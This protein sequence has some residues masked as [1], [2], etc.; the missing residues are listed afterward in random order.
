YYEREKG[1]ERETL[2]LAVE[3]ALM[4][5]SRKSLSADKEIRVEVDRDTLQI[6]AFRPSVV[7]GGFPNDESEISL[8]DAREVKP[9]AGHRCCRG[10]PSVAL[11]IR[12]LLVVSGS[13]VAGFE[14]T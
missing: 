1:I 9:D 6:N 5:A 11:H 3:N 12:S 4:T 14:T 2:I 7:V 8:L 13:A 10:L